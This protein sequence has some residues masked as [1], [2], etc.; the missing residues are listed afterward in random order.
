[1]PDCL[2]RYSDI[3]RVYSTKTTVLGRGLSYSLENF[4]GVIREIKEFTA[5]ATSYRTL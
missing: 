4:S 5:T 2:E 3:G 1:M